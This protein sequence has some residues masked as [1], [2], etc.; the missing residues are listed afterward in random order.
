VATISKEARRREI[1]EAALEVFGEK[2]YHASKVEDIVS[3][4]GVARGTFYLYFED[5]RAIFAE[6]LDAFV[7]Q[8][9]A[10]VVRIDPS[11]NPQR[12]LRANVQRALDLMF[13]EPR[14]AR[15]LLSHAV[16]L[17]PE[18]DRKLKSFYDA[19]AADL[20]RAIRLGQQM[21]F[22]RACDA[23]IIAYALLGSVKEIAARVVAGEDLEREKVADECLHQA[24]FGLLTR[25]WDRVEKP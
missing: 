14:L 4:A 8:L 21:E 20:E 15:I 17:D 9:R 18:F 7:A 24:L 3:R 1:L 23:R 11:D 5:K 13:G 12:Q 10:A 6:L 2:G 19:L 25:R 22:V 16:G